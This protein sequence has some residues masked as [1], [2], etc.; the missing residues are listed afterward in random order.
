MSG[1]GH[2]AHLGRCPHCGKVSYETRSLARKAKRQTHVG[3]DSIRAYPCPEGFFFHLGHQYS[4]RETY[5]VAAE[6]PPGGLS[7]SGGRR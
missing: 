5:R 1:L 2:V 7:L 4:D 6:R 3:D